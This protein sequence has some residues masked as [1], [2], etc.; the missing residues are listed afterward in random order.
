MSPGFIRVTASFDLA[1]DQR[2]VAVVVG[3]HARLDAVG[4]EVVVV[5]AALVDV[6]ARQAAVK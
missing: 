2:A 1:T 5:D 6:A 3:L 4:L